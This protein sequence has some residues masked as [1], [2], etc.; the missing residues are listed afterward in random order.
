MYKQKMEI[1]YLSHNNIDLKKWDICIQNAYNSLIYA[2]SWY[3]DIVSPNWEA[4]VYNDYE[5][6][7]PLP[8]KRKC[9][10]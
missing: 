4:L 5:Y 1:K 2:E 9:L 7:M 6:V 3:L 10:I 8:L